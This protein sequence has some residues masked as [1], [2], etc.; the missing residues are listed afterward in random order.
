[1]RS[2]AQKKP[3]N[4]A[5]RIPDFEGDAAKWF[6]ELKATGVILSTYNPAEIDS[7]MG[8][9]LTEQELTKLEAIVDEIKNTTE[10]GP[11]VLLVSPER[12]VTIAM[13]AKSRGISRKHAN[14]QFNQGKIEGI[15]IGGIKFVF[16]NDASRKSVML[17]TGPEL[18]GDHPNRLRCEV[19]I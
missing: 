19:I 14:T 8:F 5:N 10:E 7:L 2:N 12:L 16:T 6:S 3:R 15:T 18:N 13:F 4:P 11:E 17:E 1:M 9:D